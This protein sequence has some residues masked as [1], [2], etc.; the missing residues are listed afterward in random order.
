[1]RALLELG[2]SGARRGI[3][4]LL[5]LDCSAGAWFSHCGKDLARRDVYDTVGGF[6][7]HFVPVPPSRACAA[8]GMASVPF[9]ILADTDP[10]SSY[11]GDG[12]GDGGGFCLDWHMP[13]SQ[14]R[15]CCRQKRCLSLKG[16]GYMG[17]IVGCK[18]CNVRVLC[19]GFVLEAVVASA[20]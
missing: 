18:V 14:G 20:R 1:M 4:L 13:F 17:L 5:F 8:T 12:D 7:G 11:P 19:F 2:I 3:R 15:S 9:G 16:S 10:G 6:G